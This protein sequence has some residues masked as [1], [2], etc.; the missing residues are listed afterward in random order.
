MKA[1]AQS[2]RDGDHPGAPGAQEVAEGEEAADERRSDIVKDGRA[3]SS[4]SG[5]FNSS[6]QRAVHRVLRCDGRRVSGVKD[7]HGDE[8]PGVRPAGK[9]GGAADGDHGDHE[10]LSVGWKSTPTRPLKADLHLQPKASDALKFDPS[11]LLRVC[12]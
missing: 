5:S 7:G 8:G 2:T 11:K 6:H 4:W 1:Q 3:C 10:K 9:Y 12:E